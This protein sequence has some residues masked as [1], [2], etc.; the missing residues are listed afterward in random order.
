MRNKLKN[1]YLK[2]K[3]SKTRIKNKNNLLKKFIIIKFNPKLIKKIYEIIK[4]KL[5]SNKHNNNKI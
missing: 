3:I 4:I 5:N 2:N 1:K